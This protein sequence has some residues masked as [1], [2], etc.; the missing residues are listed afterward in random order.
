ML[1]WTRLPYESIL[2]E[3]PASVFQA[4]LCLRIVCYSREGKPVKKFIV[5]GDAFL[6]PMATV[7]TSLLNLNALARHFFSQN[8]SANFPL[9]IVVAPQ[10]SPQTSLELL[11][12]P[13]S[14]P[15][16]RCRPPF[17]AL[18]KLTLRDSCFSRYQKLRTS[19]ILRTSAQHPNLLDGKWGRMRWLWPVYEKCALPKTCILVLSTDSSKYFTVGHVAIP[20]ILVLLHAHLASRQC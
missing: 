5:L 13:L 9:S 17:A 11:F 4:L 16:P 10:S 2:A 20:S 6:F 18:G 12:D 8:F 19:C 1:R 14:T 7:R 15:L 3:H